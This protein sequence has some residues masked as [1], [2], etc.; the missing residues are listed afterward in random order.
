MLQINTNEKQEKNNM[1]G[2]KTR[3]GLKIK[4]VA[5]AVGELFSHIEVRHGSD[6]P[7][8]LSYQGMF[9]CALAAST[10][11]KQ[12]VAPWIA[13]TTNGE[14]KSNQVYQQIRSVV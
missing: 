8:V 3:D 14:Y 2:N 5:R 11:V 7:Y 13:R 6:H 12:H 10:D 4:A 9:P 1:G